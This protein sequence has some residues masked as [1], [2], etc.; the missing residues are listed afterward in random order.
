M[1]LP[2]HGCHRRPLPLLLIKAQHRLLLLLLPPH[3]PCRVGRLHRQ[4]VLVVRRQLGR[5][6]LLVV[7]RQLGCLLLLVVRRQLG[8]LLL[9][10]VL[11]V[12]GR[13]VPSLVRMR[14]LRRPALPPL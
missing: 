6:L 4:P 1:R 7:G 12:R 10:L 13:L 14:V 5:L 8:R 11:L 2:L 3:F 9:V